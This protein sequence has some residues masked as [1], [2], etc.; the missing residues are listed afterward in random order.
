MLHA[1]CLIVRFLLRLFRY[2]CQGVAKD[3]TH[4]TKKDSMDKAR[5]I[6]KDMCLVNIIL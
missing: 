6:T 2:A 3:L 1:L 4:R 5:Y